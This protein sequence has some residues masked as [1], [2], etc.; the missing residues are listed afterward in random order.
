M[1]EAKLL[2]GV[3][4]DGISPVAA[5]FAPCVVLQLSFVGLEHST[6]VYNQL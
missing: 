4:V 2:R 3:N 1:F 5:H 6:A